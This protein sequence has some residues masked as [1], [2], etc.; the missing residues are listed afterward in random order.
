M[1]KKATGAQL[2]A[3]VLATTKS[4]AEVSVEYGDKSLCFHVKQHASLRNVS[5]CT[6]AIVQMAMPGGVCDISFFD[7]AAALQL[8]AYFTDLPLDDAVTKKQEEDDKTSQ[9][10][11]LFAFF[12]RCNIL[13]LILDNCVVAREIYNNAKR[14]FDKKLDAQCAAEAARQSTNNLMDVLNGL[15]ENNEEPKEE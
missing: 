13:E 9:V 14:L 12:D 2:R 11:M 15:I 3:A 4:D 6:Y 7:F 5:E 8:A 1:T 10:E